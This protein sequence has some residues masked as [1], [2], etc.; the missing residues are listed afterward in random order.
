MLSVLLDLSDIKILC[1][2][3]FHC[4]GEIVYGPLPAKPQAEHTKG[5]MYFQT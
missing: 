2:T 3:D 4:S 1:I 5:M